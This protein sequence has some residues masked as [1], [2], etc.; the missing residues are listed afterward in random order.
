MDRSE[1]LRLVSRCSLLGVDLELVV[2][3]SIVGFIGA[4]LLL[5][6]A[7]PMFA[8]FAIANLQSY[9][10]LDSGSDKICFRGGPPGD[11][12]RGLESEKSASQ[13]SR[14]TVSRKRGYFD[15]LLSGEAR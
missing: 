10:E 9:A 15:S 5:G 7:R 8:A 14:P 3:G 6:A 4:L 2:S 11:N 1:C 13:Q 12:P